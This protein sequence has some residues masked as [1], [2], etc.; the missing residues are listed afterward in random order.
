MKKILMMAAALTIIGAISPNKADAACTSI[1]VPN[2]TN[3]Y[4]QTCTT[5]T[6]VAV[7]T[8]IGCAAGIVG[9]AIAANTTQR[10]ELTPAEATTCGLLYW[11]S[12]RP[13]R[14]P[15]APLVVTKG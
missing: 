11:I 12:P 5:H 9:T 6:P 7:W 4:I 15:V 8:V 14:A 1:L 3:T 10:R 13:W 2:T